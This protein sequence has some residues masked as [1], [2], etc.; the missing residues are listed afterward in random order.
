MTKAYL[1][2]DDVKKLEEAATCLRDRLL[3]RI[4]FHLGCRVS[5]AL[6]LK[7]EDIDLEQG[8]V[9]IE[10]LKARL[11][12][13]CPKCGARLGKSHT[14]CPKCGAKVK[15]VVTK[16]KEHRRLRTLPVDSDTLEMPA[17]FIKKDKTRGLIFRI[18]RHR[19]WQII[20]E[21]AE[22]AGLPKLINP[23]TGR[24]HNVSPHRLRD[25]FAVHAVKLDDSGDG[26]RL[27]QEH[28]GHQSFNTTARYRKVAGEEHREWYQRLWE[29]G[30]R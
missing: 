8:T 23:E 24:S 20:R 7:V 14:Y 29:K 15:E 21:Y 19:A 26:L 10:H 16:E 12:L 28:L 30:K 27:L 3:I 9:T 11:R 25:A 6:A 1:E 18:N 4:L 22:K 2:I 17:D 13:C 5:E